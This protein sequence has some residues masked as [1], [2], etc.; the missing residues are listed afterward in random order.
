MDK[1]KK[2]M[3]AF[4]IFMIVF[5]LFMLILSTGIIRLPMP[6]QF[7]LSLIPVIIGV[8]MLIL[9]LKGKK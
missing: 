2:Q 8:V 4:C 1:K 9:V 6:I 3:V 7:I 5:G